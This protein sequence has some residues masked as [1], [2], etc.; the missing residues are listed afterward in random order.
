[1]RAS[2]FVFGGQPHVWFLNPLAPLIVRLR[3]RRMEVVPGGNL[4]RRRPTRTTTLARRD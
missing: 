4:K 2:D 1:M 3:W